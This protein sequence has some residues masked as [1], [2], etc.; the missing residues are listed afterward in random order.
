MT[1]KGAG[2][3]TLLAGLLG[4]IYSF[5]G[6]VGL[7]PAPDLDLSTRAVLL[8]SLLLAVFGY[9]I[10]KGT[11]TSALAKASLAIS[12]LM[13]YEP[14]ARLPALIGIFGSSLAIINAR[15]KPK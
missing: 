3:I 9:M 15:K 2:T 6:P 4:L 7:P 10:R 8:G 1:V 14:Y 13:L 11:A 5:T 12:I